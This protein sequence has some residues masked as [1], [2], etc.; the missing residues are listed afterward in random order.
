RAKPFLRAQWIYSKGYAAQEGRAGRWP[1]DAKPKALIPIV[2]TAR[3]RRWW[4]RSYGP[5][6]HWLGE[7]GVVPTTAETVKALPLMYLVLPYLR[8]AA[9]VRGWFEG[10]RLRTG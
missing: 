5:D 9:Q 3:A 8:S 4:G 1:S 2:P 7:N 10:R 6:R